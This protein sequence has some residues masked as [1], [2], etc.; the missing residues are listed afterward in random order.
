MA[1][2]TSASSSTNISIQQKTSASSNTRCPNRRRSCDTICSSNSNCFL[3][4]KKPQNP[5]AVKSCLSKNHNVVRER[6]M[7]AKLVRLR[8]LQS[9]LN[10]ANYHLM[11]L[12]KENRA[13]KTLQRR[14]DRA[15]NSYE[16]INADLPRLIKSH[17]EDNRILTERNRTLRKTIKELNEQIKIKDEELNSIRDQLKHLTMLSRDKHLGEREKLKEQLEDA[18]EQ[19]RKYETEINMLHR[20][21][22]LELKN[23]KQRINLEI[24]KNKSTQ[25]ELSQ[26]LSEID[27]LSNENKTG[28]LPKRRFRSNSGQR[29]SHSM[30]CLT[31]NNETSELDIKEDIQSDSSTEIKLEPINIRD[32]PHVQSTMQ[33][34]AEKIKARLSGNPVH[35]ISDVL[36]KLSLEEEN[37]KKSMYSLR[38]S[39]PHSTKL[40]TL[41][42][43]S[44]EESLKNTAENL[45][46]CKSN[47][48]ETIMKVN[49]VVDKQ[50][51]IFEASQLE[52]EK[53]MNDLKE[54]DN[55]DNKIR[56]NQFDELLL[57]DEDFDL[58]NKIWED[59]YEFRKAVNP[60]TKKE[61]TVGLEEKKKL[62]ATLRDIDNGNSIEEVPQGDVDIKK[63]RLMKDL[64]G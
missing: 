11:E 30:V 8:N 46:E 3:Q 37:I 55:M 31:N 38:S 10:D 51:E 20:K 25:R 22:M 23:S 4:K 59:E 56:D 13:L 18:K 44:S 50:T 27:K 7:S 45:E 24:A 40:E 61:P 1:S 33:S 19:N 47:I 64:F 60:T 52:S 28:K 35:Q 6:V 54:A 42:K 34:P 14:Q 9:Q 63:S 21:H 53:I 32:S 29:Q 36:E 49:K 26:A 58:V 57:K 41:H 12:A 17:E 39:R 43:K 5:L 15:L 62:L 48:I 2:A 16:G